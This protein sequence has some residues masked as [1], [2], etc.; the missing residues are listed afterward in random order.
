MSEPN[1][2]KA[3]NPKEVRDAAEDRQRM[4]DHIGLQIGQIESLEI[5]NS[6][7]AKEVLRLRYEL[8]KADAK[9]ELILHSAAAA[10]LIPEVAPGESVIEK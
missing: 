10:A 7:M 9:L 1:A 5:G 8:A 6:L 3:E 4:L 2:A